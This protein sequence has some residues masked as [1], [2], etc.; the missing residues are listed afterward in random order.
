MPTKEIINGNLYIFVS[1]AND[2]SS[3]GSINGN[4]ITYTTDKLVEIWSAKIEYDYQDQLITIPIP[5]SKGNRGDTPY[6]RIIDLKRINEV[7]SVEGGLED[8]DDESAKD[9][10]NNLLTMGKEHGVLTVVWNET[11]NGEQTLWSQDPQNNNYGAF[12]NKMKFTEISGKLSE[13]KTETTPER[14]LNVNIQLFR[15]KD[16]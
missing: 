13:S 16:M 4:T 10:R 5:I 7:I 1:I 12:I 15:G 11:E 14:K 2:G 6:N 3:I 8:E 9:K